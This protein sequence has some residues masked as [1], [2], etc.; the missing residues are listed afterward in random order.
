MD[1]GSDVV[2]TPEW[3][4]YRRE[5]FDLVGGDDPAEVQASTPAALR[6]RVATASGAGVLRIRPAE[7]EWSLVELVGHMFDAEV[8]SSARY[9]WVLGHDR[10]WLDG[11]DQDAVAAVSGHLDAD[12]EILLTAW[13][14]LRRA[15]LD[16]WARS[17]PDQRRREGVHAEC[18]ASTYEVLFVEMA[19][20]DRETLAQIDRTLE[21][22]LPA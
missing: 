22:V 18:G 21:A 5:L 7:G 6:E 4:T 17:T 14:G 12:P 2:V 20:H 15:N 13:A 3:A 19:G 11:Y 9:R 16:L 8:Y 1:T 10:P